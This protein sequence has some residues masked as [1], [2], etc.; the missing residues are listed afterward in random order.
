MAALTHARKAE[1]EMLRNL[2]TE[3][4]ERLSEGIKWNA[5]SY[6]FKGE[7]VLTFR[8]QPRDQVQLV[9]H[10][11]AKVRPEPLNMKIEDPDKLLVWAAPDRASMS[12]SSPEDIQTKTESL[13]QIV[14]QWLDQLDTALN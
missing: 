10:T 4:D 11:G 1:I 14:R 6:V 9:L 8:L 5:P 7:D 13:K 3:T 12:F 2:I